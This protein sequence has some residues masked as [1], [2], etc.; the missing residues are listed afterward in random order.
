MKKICTGCGDDKELDLFHKETA[1][2]FGR[3]SKC[4]EC[5]FKKTQAWKLNNQER[6]IENR[7]RWNSQ[8][9][10][11]H[12]EATYKWREENP[13]IHSEYVAQYQKDRKAS[14][15]K[16]KLLS[17]MRSLMY[18]HLTRKNLKKH[19]KLEG[20]LGCV[21]E[22]FV[23]TIEQQFVGIMS[24]DNYGSYWS[25]DHI[26]PCNQAKT[27]DEMIKLQ[28]YLNLRP[29]KTHGEDGNFAK[30]DNKTPEAEEL[31]L[32]LLGRSWID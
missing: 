5:I 11:R 27:E 31:C 12:K 8:N 9:K 3:K 13:D 1:G 4:A 29:M 24:W 32:K 26:C 21:F 25:I 28:S 10:D 6:E 2:K 16:F 22:D 23:M 30:S 19:K 14:D 15:P 7:K 20:Y 17:N 18:N